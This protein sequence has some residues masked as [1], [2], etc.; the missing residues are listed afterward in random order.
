M[1]R[2]DPS[3]RNPL[4]H[5]RQIV[6]A[7][8]ALAASAAPPTFALQQGTARPV[9]KVAEDRSL[10]P[11]QYAAK[12]LPDPSRPWSPADYKQ[13]HAALTRIAAEDP[14]QLP[15]YASDRSGKVFARMAAAE[16]LAGITDRRATHRERHALFTG[17]GG[18]VDIATIYVKATTEQAGSF[19][20]ELVE[21]HAAALRLH[22]AGAQ[23]SEDFFATIPPDDPTR[24]RR[25]QA[26]SGMRAAGAKWIRESLQAFASAAFRKS[27]LV[28]F[29]RDLRTLVPEYL[30]F[31]PAESRDAIA[32]DLARLESA[33]TDAELK[34]VVRALLDATKAV[35][36]A[37]APPE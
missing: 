33:E 15:R 23:W 16:N 24:A 8:L 17:Y 5:A 22:L 14:R 21:L 35:K 25:V 7:M 30:A 11:D 34:A 19:D 10:T 20:A 2:P 36:P 1:R 3:A 9:P 12:G 26:L 28:R 13:A 37:P 18:L 27:E 31:L 4:S 6:F 29:A 32:S